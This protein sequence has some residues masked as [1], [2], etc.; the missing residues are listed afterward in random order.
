MAQKRN[1]YLWSTNEAGLKRMQTGGER[2]A[3]DG[4]L[5]E[6]LKVKRANEEGLERVRNEEKGVY[7]GD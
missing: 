5:C 1:P 4:L 7:H 6:E 3:W 2:M